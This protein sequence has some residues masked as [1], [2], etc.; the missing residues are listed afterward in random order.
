MC[1]SDL[2][3]QELAT[4]WLSHLQRFYSELGI[5]QPVLQS[6]RLSEVNVSL[7]FMILTQR[8][9]LRC[10]HL[11]D[12]PGH[13]VHLGSFPELRSFWIYESGRVLAHTS[14]VQRLERCHNVRLEGPV[15]RMLRLQ[16]LELP[17][18]QRDVNILATGAPKL[19]YL[20]HPNHEVVFDVSSW[21]PNGFGCLEYAY[22]NTKS[23][24][25]QGFAWSHVIQRLRGVTILQE[26]EE[27]AYARL[28]TSSDLRALDLFSTALPPEGF[29]AQTPRMERLQL[30]HTPESLQPL[31]RWTKLKFLRMGKQT[32]PADKSLAVSLP[33]SWKE[34][35]YLRFDAANITGITFGDARAQHTCL[36]RRY[37]HLDTVSDEFDVDHLVKTFPHLRHLTLPWLLVHRHQDHLRRL[38]HLRSLSILATRYPRTRDS[39]FL[40]SFSQLRVLHSEHTLTFGKPPHFQVY[41]CDDLIYT[42]KV[43]PCMLSALPYPAPLRQLRDACGEGFFW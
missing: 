9:T 2:T 28:A 40:N 35:Q 37:M 1:S 41:S 42:E 7:W 27:A 29:V 17:F 33:D 36:S 4:R 38:K 15:S 30:Q 6:I 10:V 23:L 26:Y 19:Q 31:F 22:F 20:S 3:R 11:F 21:D 8:E 24:L 32:H 12:V 18:D 13:V 34:I 5:Q 43:T 25:A 14:G 16:V 39:G